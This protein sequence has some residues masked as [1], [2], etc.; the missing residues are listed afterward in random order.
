MIDGSGEI[1]LSDQNETS[2][3]QAFNSVRFSGVSSSLSEVLTFGSDLTVR[4]LGTIQADSSTDALRFLGD[5]IAEDG[6]LTLIRVD[7]GGQ[8]L[9]VSERDGGQLTISRLRMRSLRW[10]MARM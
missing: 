4:G 5:V 9:S 10:R 8:V 1:V 2:A 3:F 7:Q 6:A